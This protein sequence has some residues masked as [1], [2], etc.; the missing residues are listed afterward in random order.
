MARTVTH[1]GLAGQDTFAVPFGADAASDLTVTVD[2]VAAS[3]TF[4]GSFIILSSPLATDASVTIVVTAPSSTGS[5]S[6]T[7]ATLQA[8]LNAIQNQ[9]SGGSNGP[10]SS[11]ANV[12]AVAAS[13]NSVQLIGS[14]ASRHPDGVDVVND[15]STANLFVR[16]GSSAAT[17][18]NYS[19]KLAPG[20]SVLID[21]FT[22][23]IQGVWDGASGSARITEYL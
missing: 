12:T 14:N 19:Y 22:G 3:F 10:P 21:N 17:T 23:P 5:S 20:Q 8:V 7:E 11:A 13:T 6:A 1:A 16:P 18:S 15:S 2:G 9:N 4:N